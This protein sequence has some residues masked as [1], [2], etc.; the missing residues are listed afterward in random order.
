MPFARAMSVGRLHRFSRPLSTAAFGQLPEDLVA[1]QSSARAFFMAELHPLLRQMDDEDAFPAVGAA[2][3][4][5]TPL[6]SPQ[7]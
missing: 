5:P 3:L 2:R 7:P 1:L 6:P 4:E